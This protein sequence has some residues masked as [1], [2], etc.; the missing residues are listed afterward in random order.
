MSAPLS[1]NRPNLQHLLELFPLA[2]DLNEYEL[3]P[4]D[5]VPAPY[6]QLL[7]HEHHMTVTVEEHHGG[8]V[9]VSIL[10]RRHDGNY[11]AR[12]ILLVLQKSGK[13]VQ[14][15]IV[16]INLD[17]CSKDV[18]NEIVAGNT[19]LG[20]I[21]I[22]HNVLRRIEPTAFLRITPGFELIHEFGLAE[23]R[24]TYGRLAIIH[25]DGKPAIELLEVVAPE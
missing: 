12:R 24:P 19:P 13:V 4:A 15:G 7:V 6:Q 2:D 9:D 10:N 23:S 20:R 5:N 22:N 21:L 25:C 8:H 18:R 11:Y 1:T 3:V 17:F 16:R 14:F